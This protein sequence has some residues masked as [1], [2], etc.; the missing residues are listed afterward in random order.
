M[1]RNEWRGYGVP[2]KKM[3]TKGDDGYYVGR[4]RSERR[5]ECAQELKAMGY[6]IKRE[7]RNTQREVKLLHRVGARRIKQA[8]TRIQHPVSAWRGRWE[9]RL[10]DVYW[11][12]E[13]EYVDQQLMAY[14]R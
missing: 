10:G 4:N 5:R 9:Q 7:D 3:R 14:A 2:G 11:C 1:K 6:D 13:A 8:Y 12:R